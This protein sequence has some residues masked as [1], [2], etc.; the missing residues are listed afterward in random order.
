MLDIKI[1]R[2]KNNLVYAN[3]RSLKIGL[4]GPDL[5]LM[6]FKEPNLIVTVQSEKPTLL[7]SSKIYL[8]N[9]VNLKILPL[10]LEV[11]MAEMGDDQWAENELILKDKQEMGNCH[12]YKI[13]L[14]DRPVVEKVIKYGLYFSCQYLEQ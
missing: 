14:A 9:G 2:I 5:E 8:F 7:L 12:I 1:E 4:E 13:I 6:T 11:Y 10:G 3:P